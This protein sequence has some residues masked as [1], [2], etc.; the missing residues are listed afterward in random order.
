MKQSISDQKELSAQLRV[1]IEGRIIAE[2]KMADL[3]N[4]LEKK[5]AERT[6]QLITGNE[7]ILRVT[8]TIAH[9]LRAPV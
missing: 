8:S 3:N 4:S 5:V 2:T 7:E 9:D 6:S 1:E